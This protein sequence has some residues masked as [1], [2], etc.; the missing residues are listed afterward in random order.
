MPEP[1][2]EEEA[3][4]TPSAP[5]DVPVVVAKPRTDVVGRSIKH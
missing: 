1:R 2:I 3:A 4:S 5:A